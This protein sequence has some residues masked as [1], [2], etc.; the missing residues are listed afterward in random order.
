MNGRVFAKRFVAVALLLFGI[1]SLGGEGETGTKAALLAVCAVLAILLFRR[2]A[3]DEEWMRRY[4]RGE[5]PGQAVERGLE[6]AVE[7]RVGG[8]PDPERK[9]RGVLVGATVLHVLAAPFL[10]LRDLLKMQK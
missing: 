9:V 8:S 6:E 5:L 3:R 1:A 7:E 10:I 4:E 2:T